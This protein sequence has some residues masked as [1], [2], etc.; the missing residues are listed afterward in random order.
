MVTK[1]IPCHVEQGQR[2]YL[3]NSVPLG[4]K[5]PPKE[6]NKKKE[7]KNISRLQA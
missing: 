3:S 6:A 5:G 4:K 2:D 1:Q 7:L